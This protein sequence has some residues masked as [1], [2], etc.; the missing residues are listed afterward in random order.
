[1]DEKLLEIQIDVKMKNLT[2]MGAHRKIRVLFG[3]TECSHTSTYCY[4]DDDDERTIKHCAW[5]GA[6]NIR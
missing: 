3:F 2:P 6:K 4:W 1:M 5:C